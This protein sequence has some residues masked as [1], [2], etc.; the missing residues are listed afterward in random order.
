[1]PNCN[2]YATPKDHEVLL[3]W[4]FEEATCRVF[5]LASDFEQPLKEFRSTD[6][7]I[8]QFE[9]THSTGVNW[10]QIYLQLYVLGAAPPFVPKRISLNPEACNGAT[11][12]YGAEGWGLVQLYLGAESK[13]GI[14]MS[15]TN[16]NS[17]KRAEV[18]AS[19]ITN[20]QEP[21][22]WDF[23]KVTA[24][25]SRLNRQIKKLS[26]AKVGSCLILPN[27]FKLR[28]A[29]TLLVGIHHNAPIAV[30]R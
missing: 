14:E 8:S 2:F 22:L 11:F 30:I 18:W 17:Q 29:G 3:H 24:F 28:Q 1:M 20:M 10:H 13:H 4:L 25:S 21:S 5:E 15:H 16:H 26:V 27:A 23:K 6:E 19:T 7:V 9:R 12:R